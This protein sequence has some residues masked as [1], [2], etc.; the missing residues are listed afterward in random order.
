MASADLKIDHKGIGA[1]L[2][3]GR[4]QVPFNQRSYAWREKHVRNLLQDLDQEIERADGSE[5][6]LG[7]IVLIQK[8]SEPP[9]IV[10]GQQRLAT[11]SILLARIR[12][13]LIRLNRLGSAQSIEESFLTNIDRKTEL[14]V[15]RLQL[16][17]EDNAFYLDKILPPNVEV[18][19]LPV[20][21][22]N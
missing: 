4:L 15:S 19:P 11:V 10:D 9:T 13:H 16:N 18:T 22:S 8:G 17:L 21:R 6:F 20:S 12:D 7:T 3:E 2:H 14:R 1:L 5:Y